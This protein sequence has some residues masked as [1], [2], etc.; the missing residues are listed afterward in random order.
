MSSTILTPDL[1]KEAV[2]SRRFAEKMMSPMPFIA[3]TTPKGL[4]DRRRHWDEKAYEDSVIITPE[5]TKFRG[6]EVDFVIFDEVA[7]IDP[8]L[9]S[10]DES[11]ERRGDWREDY[12]AWARGKDSKLAEW[13]EGS[14]TAPSEP[15]EDLTVD[16]LN[17]AMA[18]LGDDIMARKKIPKKRQ[19][20]G[21]PRKANYSGRMLGNILLS[22]TEQIENNTTLN[23]ALSD[24][25]SSSVT[26]EE[27]IVPLFEEFIQAHGDKWQ[28]TG[29][30]SL[31]AQ[32]VASSKWKSVSA[33]GGE[34]LHYHSVVIGKRDGICIKWTTGNIVGLDEEMMLDTTIKKFGDKLV[35]AQLKGNPANR[36]PLLDVLLGFS[37]EAD[38]VTAAEEAKARVKAIV[39]KQLK[40]DIDRKSEAYGDTYGA[41]A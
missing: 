23:D 12:A 29:P 27:L 5:D 15:P 9:F 1:L 10:K 39:A 35:P 8:R 41:W 25:G 20:R 13:T 21:D 3:M 4:S 16:K 17:E 14:F 19:P 11:M 24:A 28:V 7:D 22:T 31:S 40:D 2:A 33:L 6:R 37:G 36:M 26:V 38:V 34:I 18:L 32:S 30:M